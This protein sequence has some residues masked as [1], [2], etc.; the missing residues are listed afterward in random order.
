ML[1]L[2]NPMGVYWRVEAYLSAYILEV[3]ACIKE[4]CSKE[5]LVPCVVN[6]CEL[7]HFA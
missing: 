4:A 2:D 5:G 1:N 7:S 3:R 6:D